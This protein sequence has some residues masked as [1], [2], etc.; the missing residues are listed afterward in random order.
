MIAEHHE[1]P[2]VPRLYQKNEAAQM[3]R[4]SSRPLD[5]YRKEGSINSIKMRGVVLFS[6]WDIVEFLRRSRA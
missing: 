4:I 6:E 2:T 3:L 5:R 1:E